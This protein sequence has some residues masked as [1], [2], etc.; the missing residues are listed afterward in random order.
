MKLAEAFVTTVISFAN[1][2]G[3]VGK[4]TFSCQFAYYLQIKKH[5]KVLLIDMDA[6]GNSTGTMLGDAELASTNSQDLFEDD[7]E[8][9]NVQTTERG[10]D[11]I[12]TEATAQA[13]DVEALPLEK[14]INPQA[15]LVEVFPKYDF[16]IIDCPPTLGR[17]L[18]AALIMSDFVVTPQKLSGY[19]VDGVAALFETINMIQEGPNADL[20]IL[21][22]AIN[23]WKETAAQKETLN[24]LK[25]TDMR[26]Y[27]FEHK[28][29]DRAPFDVAAR[30]TPVW[31]T[32]GGSRAF[33][34]IQ[35]LFEEM[36]GKIKKLQKN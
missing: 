29:R 26:E 21:G 18:T 23:E 16:V 2:K 5:K 36:I 25:N 13:Y 17:R 33:E 22:I 35:G 7:L 10:I 3:G 14:V 30:S 31:E 9:V 32:R 8:A 20:K 1:Q 34:E 6:Q 15:H 19:A 12:G 28:V 11:I 24:A 4:T 27:L